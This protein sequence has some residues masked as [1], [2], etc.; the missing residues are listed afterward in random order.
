MQVCEQVGPLQLQLAHRA[1]MLFPDIRSLAKLVHNRLL[2][3]DSIQLTN[4]VPTV[5]S[6]S[7]QHRHKAAPKTIEQCITGG[8]QCRCLSPDTRRGRCHA[9]QDARPKR[10]CNHNLLWKREDSDVADRLATL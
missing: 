1:Q 9:V 10:R 3:A 8:T 5:D 7:H 4:T 6:A 2:P